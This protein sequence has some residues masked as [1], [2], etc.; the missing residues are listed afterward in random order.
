MIHRLFRWIV[1]YICFATNK[2]IIMRFR[3][4]ASGTKPVHPY[5]LF[6]GEGSSSYI[7]SS[8]SFKKAL[9]ST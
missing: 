5:F 8:S 9:L 1:I 6:F 3:S 4:N 2:R 7:A